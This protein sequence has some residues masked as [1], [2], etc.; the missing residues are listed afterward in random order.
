MFRLT[1]LTYMKKLNIRIGNIEVRQAAGFT[2]KYEVVKWSTNPL[3]GKEDE[4]RTTNGLGEIVYEKNGCKYSES[5]FKHP[6]SCYVVS[7]IEWNSHEPCW[8]VREVG[9][10]PFELEKDD[11]DD[12]SRL[13]R[14]IFTILQKPNDE[15][16]D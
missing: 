7:F 10:R 3:Y 14:M 11:Y 15:E 5:C 1:K 16:T 13:M 2:D 8:E 9:I 6:E 4:Y 12:W